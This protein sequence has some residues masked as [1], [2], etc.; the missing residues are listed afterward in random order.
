MELRNAFDA[1]VKFWEAISGIRKERLPIPQAAANLDKYF[2]AE[3]EDYE[4]YVDA[5]DRKPVTVLLLDEI[6]YL[7]T[8]KET[9]LYS[10]SDWPLRAV[11]NARLV[12][13]GIAN[14]INLPDKLS[15]K[16]SSRIGQKRLFFGAYDCDEIV[17]II[18]RRLGMTDEDHDV[19]YVYS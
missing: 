12:V 16:L 1:Y 6:D 17:T 15:P 10:F 18:Q 5:I 4:D 19:R 2:L 9:V 8:E 11:S 13:V 7:V 14:T 3:D